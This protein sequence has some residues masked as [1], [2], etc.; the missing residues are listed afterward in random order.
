[1]AGILCRE[2]SNDRDLMEQKFSEI[3]KSAIIDGVPEIDDEKI[4]LIAGHVP[5]R[6]E[7]SEKQIL[8]VIGMS[9]TC[10]GLLLT[11]GL[12]MTTVHPLLRTIAMSI[13]AINL[14]LGPVVALVIVMRRYVDVCK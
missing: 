9:S 13:P 1:M 5:V 12:L 7:A 14:V 11:I 10:L 2:Q 4:R 3:I 8:F 6:V